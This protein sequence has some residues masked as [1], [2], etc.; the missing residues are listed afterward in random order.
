MHSASQLT[1]LTRQRRQVCIS[2]LIHFTVF[3]AVDSVHLQILLIIVN[4]CPLTKLEGGLNL[5][6][7]ADDDAVI[8]RPPDRTRGA[9]NAA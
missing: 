6:H 7:G 2:H 5:L 9:L 3:T 1:N 8:W 4:A